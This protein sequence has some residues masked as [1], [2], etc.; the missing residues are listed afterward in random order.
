MVLKR[1]CFGWQNSGTGYT[2][3]GWDLRLDSTFTSCQVGPRLCSLAGCCY[4]LDPGFR[5][6][7]RH[8][9]IIMQ[10]LTL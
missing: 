2:L 9:L 6:S 8:C 4:W 10:G 7:F 5:S 3:I 1:L